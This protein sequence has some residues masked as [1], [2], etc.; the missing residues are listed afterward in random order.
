[1][2]ALTCSLGDLF[3]PDRAGRLLGAF[4]HREALDMR[5]RRRIGRRGPARG[6]HRARGPAPRER[7]ARRRH[8]GEG[9]SDLGTARQTAEMG[10]GTAAAPVAG[11]YCA[12]E[13]VARAPNVMVHPYAWTR[14]QRLRPRG[15]AA[16]R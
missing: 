6:Q 11:H 15:G 2:E 14:L 1:M 13:R 10:G 5:G 12:P 8:D 16:H 4:T 9:V 7:A 3:A